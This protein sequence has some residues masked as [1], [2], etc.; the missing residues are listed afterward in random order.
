[1]NFGTD[2]NISSKRFREIYNFH[3]HTI[4]SRKFLLS[5]R[6]NKMAQKQFSGEEEEE[7]VKKNRFV[8]RHARFTCWNFLF[9]RDRKCSPARSPLAEFQNNSHTFHIFFSQKIHA[10]NCTWQFNVIILRQKRCPCHQ[11]SMRMKR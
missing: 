8:P 2:Q 5:Q 3:P 10:I 4:C 7:S 11:T 1:M 9:A 6:E